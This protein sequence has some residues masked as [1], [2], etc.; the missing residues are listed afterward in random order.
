M[1]RPSL[2]FWCIFTARSVRFPSSTG[3]S[4]DESCWG[5]MILPD[6]RQL[7]TLQL[8]N[9]CSCSHSQTN[10]SMIQHK[11]FWSRLKF[12]F[13]WITTEESCFQANS[14]CTITAVFPWKKKKYTY[15][16][17]ITKNLFKKNEPSLRSFICSFLEKKIRKNVLFKKEGDLSC[18]SFPHAA[19]WCI[20]PVSVHLRCQFTGN[21]GT[22]AQLSV[23][24]A[25]GPGSGVSIY[26]VLS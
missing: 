24:H 16:S 25:P 11:L 6:E 10:E 1:E 14:Y 5:R 2:P 26:R 23:P 20:A 4:I 15:S 21:T 12:A 8:R 18:P 19:P 7:H 3:V 9:S 22:T 17:Y 13:T